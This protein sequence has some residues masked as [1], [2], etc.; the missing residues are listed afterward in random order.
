MR[1]LALGSR[2]LVQAGHWCRAAISWPVTGA[3]QLFRVRLWDSYQ[4]IGSLFGSLE[5]WPV[6]E[7]V[8]RAC[9][10]VA[11]PGAAQL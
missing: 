5:S 4:F 9:D 11:F 7:H 8:T 3:G 6:P 1:R 10:S 2:S